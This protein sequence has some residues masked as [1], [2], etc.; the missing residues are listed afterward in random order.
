[1]PRDQLGKNQSRKIEISV[2][3]SFAAQ[4]FVFRSW[5]INVYG[6]FTESK[7]ASASPKEERLH[8]QRLELLLRPQ[9]GLAA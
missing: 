8:H 6:T 2:P 3:A 9:T 7:T 1:M 5:A 4:A